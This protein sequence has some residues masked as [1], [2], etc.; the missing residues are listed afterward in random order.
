MSPFGL[1]SRGAGENY[2]PLSTR[3]TG[4]P[5]GLKPRQF[6]SRLREKQR[7]H[8]EKH[9]EKNTCLIH[10]DT[11]SCNIMADIGR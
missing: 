6:P 10:F 7:K 9:V 3:P 11:T 2:H 5:R 8:M 1:R 4:A